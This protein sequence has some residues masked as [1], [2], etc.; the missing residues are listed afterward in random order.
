MIEKREKKRG[1][2]KGGRERGRERGRE[3]GTIESSKCLFVIL[4]ISWFLLIL[5]ASHLQ[6]LLRFASPSLISLSDSYQEQSR[7]EINVGMGRK[8]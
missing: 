3:G 5:A 8:D 1:G 7:K 4:L 2:R 6:L